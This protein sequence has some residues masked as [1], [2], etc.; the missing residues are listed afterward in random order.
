MNDAILEAPAAPPSPPV[1]TGNPRYDQLLAL[2]NTNGHMRIDELAVLLDVSSQTIRR[3]IKKLSDDGILSRYHGGV[4]QASSLADRDLGR[5]EV[6]QAEEKKRIARAV[7]DR[8]PDRS[9][10][11]LAA[12]TTIEY[13]ARALDT[14]QDLRIIT[15][16][17]RVA[18]ILYPRRDF[19][20]MIPG[21][22]LRPINSGIIGPSAQEF[23]RRFR[24]DYLVM[25]LGAI[26][27]DG[28]LLEFDVNEVAVMRIMMA[29]ARHIFVAA[30]HTK[31]DAVAPVEL[32]NSSEIDALFTDETPP[33]PLAA[34]LSQQQT[35]LVL[36]A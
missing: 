21:G 10:V 17:L 20:V 4:S 16:C 2:I 25:S 3:D 12:G 30:D 31:F 29:N 27:L 13:V 34:L 9:T 23:L 35:E 8:I 14:R 26:D 6:S 18:N 7:V 5:R 1:I 15:T 11:F 28:T 22:S 33:P 19:D 36:G 32:G 24:A